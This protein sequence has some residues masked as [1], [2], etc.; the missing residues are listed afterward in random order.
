LTQ[1]RSAALAVAFSLATCAAF[2]AFALADNNSSISLTITDSDSGMSSTATTAAS[3]ASSTDAPSASV[4]HFHKKSRRTSHSS[5]ASRSRYPSV[6]RGMTSQAIGP[7]KVM[8]RLGTVISD[9]AVIRG[10]RERY[11][12]ILSTVQKGQSLAINGETDT[13]YAVL[14]ID[15]TLG[16]INKSD[17]QLLNYQVVSNDPTTPTDAT[18][19]GA[20]MVETAKTYLNVP[21]LWGGNTRDGI[22]CSGFVKAVYAQY[23]IDLPR[24]SGDQA[25]V[26]Y[27]VPKDDFSQW[28]P[29]D[30]LYFACHHAEIDHTAMYMGNGYFI[31]ASAGHG[32]QVWVDRVD[33]AYYYAHL[34]C[35]RRSKELLG[36]PVGTPQ[37]DLTASASPSAPTGPTITTVRGTRT[38]TQA[39]ASN[40]GASDQTA[41]PSN[42]DAESSQQ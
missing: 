27:D 41:A 14:M 17:V 34:V 24:H 38:T 31:H 30:R 35:V 1:R 33:N 9:S 7:S 16:F 37:Q 23:G 36:D 8:G 29:G 40:D 6:S 26:G 2:P 19:L 13:Q 42:G 10:G 4:K 15:R 11:G 28:R 22:D 20:Q 25:N 32:R 3:D 18:G 12:R 39:V 5:A 21:Y